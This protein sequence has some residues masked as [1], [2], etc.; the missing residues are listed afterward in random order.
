MSL[1]IDLAPEFERQLREEASRKGQDTAAFA[2][3][4]LEEQLAG[5]AKRQGRER[6]RRIAALM[7][8]WNAKD[9]AD[10]DPDPVWEITP[11]SLREGR[12]D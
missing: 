7:E 1:T 4:V 5:A 10:P 8:Q 11:F 3:T 6:A 12:I 2:R 9:A